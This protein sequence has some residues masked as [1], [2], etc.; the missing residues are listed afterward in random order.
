MKWLA[1]FAV[2][3]FN[4]ITFAG[5]HEG[6][7]HTAN[8]CSTTNEKTCAHLRFEK[9]P[10]STEASEFIVHVMSPSNSQVTDVKVKLWMD[11]N[12]HGNVGRNESFLYSGCLFCHE[13]KLASHSEFY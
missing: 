4:A 11:M 8:Y 2:F 1:L 6:G 3:S 12:G 5:D 13:R 10:T 9:W 7:I